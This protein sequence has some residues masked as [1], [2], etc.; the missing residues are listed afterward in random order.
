MKIAFFILLFSI[1]CWA[2]DQGY[3][4][5]EEKM[6]CENSQGRWG[7]NPGF[8]GE[9]GDIEELDPQTLSFNKV[10]LKAARMRDFNL[11][12]RELKESVF[13][14]AHLQRANL[15]NADFTGSDLTRA[16]LIDTKIAGAKFDR[17]TASYLQ[18]SFL[19]SVHGASFENSFIPAINFW[20]CA[21]QGLN[22]RRSDLRIAELSNNNWAGAHFENANLAQA[23]FLNSDL[24]GAHFE[25]ANLT[26]AWYDRCTKLPFSETTA[27]KRGMQKADRG[28][29]PCKDIPK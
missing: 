13:S 3:R 1:S 8:F 29:T 18:L 16:A 4:Y 10:N 2:E 6:R 17:V 14:A 12:G 5:N 19:K 27:L 26:D 9:C 23:R 15:E 24:S 11:K 21:C 22:F 20:N 7:Y 28:Q 25:G